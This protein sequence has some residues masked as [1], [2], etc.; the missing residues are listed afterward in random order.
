MALSPVGRPGA[1]P[2]RPFVA[3]K[4]IKQPGWWEKVRAWRVQRKQSAKMRRQAKEAARIQKIKDAALAKAKKPAAKP[5]KVAQKAV[6]AP[7]AKAGAAADAEAVE[8][9]RRIAKM[10]DKAATDPKLAAFVNACRSKGLDPRDTFMRYCKLLMQ[11][12]VLNKQKADSR[13][14]A[15]LHGKHFSETTFYAKR[16]MERCLK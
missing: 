14:T 15:D 7:A 2:R 9:R 4:Q 16:I 11:D 6:A 3:P 12:E 1:G 8:E 13:K 10:A 5:A